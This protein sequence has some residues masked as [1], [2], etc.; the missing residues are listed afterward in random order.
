[1]LTCE[2]TTTNV[3]TSAR[4]AERASIERKYSG[5]AGVKSILHFRSWELRD[6]TSRAQAYI[7]SSAETQREVLTDVLPK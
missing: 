7:W 3:H 1:M 5:E 4:T 6:A 2:Q